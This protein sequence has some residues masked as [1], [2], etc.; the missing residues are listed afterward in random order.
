MKAIFYDRYGPPDVLE[1]R[2][3][4]RPALAPDR[5]L[6]RVHTTSVNPVDWHYM[7]GEPYLVRISE[8]ARK[9]KTNV[10][11]V[12]LAGRVEAV[13]D[14]VS[15]FKP[16]DEV[17]GAGSG[18]FAEYALAKETNLVPKPVGVSYEQGG[19]VAVAGCTAVQALR[20]HG[21][22]Q[23]G[24][25]VLINGAAGGV[26]TFAVQI[27]KALGAEVTGVCSSRNVEMVR[28]IG[29]DAVV[30]YAQ[31]DFTRAGQRYDLILDA[32]GN[33]SIRSIRGSLTPSGT[34]VFVGGGGSGRWL[35]PMVGP[36]KAMVLDRFVRQRLVSMLAKIAKDDLAFISDLMLSGQLTPVIG[37]TFTLSEA[38]D[39]VRYLEAGHARGKAN[40]TI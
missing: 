25:R 5:V 7:R 21:R 10:P 40:I 26:G 28:S 39:A 1:L 14:S 31:Q 35:G 34:A 23:A 8:G 24:Q 32:V 6:I 2:E 11:G 4:D 30:D 15:Q 38:A 3:I 18:T 9:P 19:V 27:S 37:R 17:F 16:G 33:H 20:D 29:A 36:L 13:G 12:D 22:L